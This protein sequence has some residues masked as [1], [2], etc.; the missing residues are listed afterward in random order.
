[1]GR[2]YAALGDTKQAIQYFQKV[3]SIFQRN[4]FILPELRSNYEE[5]IYYYQNE[6]DAAKEL[7][8]TRQLV[9]ADSMLRTDFPFLSAKIFREYD[10]SKLLENQSILETK[11]SRSYVFNLT[12]L[13]VAILLLLALYIKYK[14]EQKIKA[15]YKILEDKILSLRDTVGKVEPE[16]IKTVQ[17]IDIDQKIVDEVLRKLKVFED[18]AGFTE[19]GLTLHKLA[20]KFETN[21]TYL[22]TIIRDYKGVN[23]IRYLGELRINYITGKLY[24]NRRYLSYTIETLAEECGIGSRN[25]FSTLFREIN[26]MRPT[27]FIK[28]RLQN[29][30]RD[31]GI[32]DHFKN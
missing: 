16:K 5:L 6:K 27:D 22:S 29:L 21:H 1:M 32:G 9:R 17:K 24:N 28:N 2:S 18:R 13:V 7:Y 12:L 30:T 20:A 14:E 15:Q 11:F 10:Q 26:G 23:F 25:T 4:Q 31:E 3:D 19:S 8:Y